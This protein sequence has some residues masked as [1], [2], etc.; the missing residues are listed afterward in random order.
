MAYEKIFQFR[1]A[2]LAIQPPIW[3]RVQVPGTMAL[4]RLHRV[5]QVVMG[6][7]DGR[8]VTSTSSWCGASGTA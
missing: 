6:W 1:I 5:F 3:R 4:G 7:T 8:T 2:L